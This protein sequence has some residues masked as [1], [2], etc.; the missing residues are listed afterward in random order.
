MSNITETSN[1]DNEWLEKSVSD[2]RIRYYEASDF[3][4]IK[5]IGRVFSKENKVDIK[6][7]YTNVSCKKDNIEVNSNI[8][9]CKCG[10]CHKM[11]HYTP[12]C[13]S[14]ENVKYD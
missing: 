2:G 8:G 3:K 7:K 1:I 14:K 10:I 13:P 9:G 6:R 5:P 11:E 12:K 4:D